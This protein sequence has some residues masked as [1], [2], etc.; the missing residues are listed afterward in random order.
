[1]IAMDCTGGWGGAAREHLAQQ[2]VRVAAFVASAKSEAKTRPK[3]EL[4]F[5]NK[6]AE[7]WWRMREALDPANM[8][9]LALPDDPVLKAELTAPTWSLRRD[10]ILVE[11]KDD[12]RERLGRSTDRAD[13]VVMASLYANEG[14]RTVV[15]SLNLTPDAVAE[16]SGEVSGF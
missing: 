6:R 14:T 5:D 2:G 11:S 12:L 1:M 4:A 15:R 16:G 8:S 3:G 9:E 7:S 10:R 13:A